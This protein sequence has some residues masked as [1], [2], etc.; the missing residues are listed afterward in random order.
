MQIVF[1]GMCASM[2][3]MAVMTVIVVWNRGPWFAFPVALSVG[4]YCW[5]KYTKIS[6]WMTPGLPLKPILLS[7]VGGV[8]VGGVALAAK[9][10]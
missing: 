3:F 8:L 5:I 7:V 9:L 2:M 1:F 4:A 10:V 6:D